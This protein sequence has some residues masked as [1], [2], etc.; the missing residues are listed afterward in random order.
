MQIPRWRPLP[1]ILKGFRTRKTARVEA[2]NARSEQSNWRRFFK[3]LALPI[4]GLVLAGAILGPVSYAKAVELGASVGR[5]SEMVHDVKLAPGDR[6]FVSVPA[7]AFVVGRDFRAGPGSQLYSLV[8]VSLEPGLLEEKGVS[9]GDILSV[10]V[11]DPLPTPVKF[12][13]S[14]EQGGL[15]LQFPTSSL[16]IWRN[17]GNTFEITKK[18]GSLFLLK[19]EPE[20]ALID[21]SALDAQIAHRDRDRIEETIRSFGRM[22]SEQ[23]SR[24]EDLLQQLENPELWV[25]E[26]EVLQ[27]QIQR[28]EA[29]L[30]SLDE[31]VQVQQARLEKLQDGS[32]PSS[33]PWIM[34]FREDLDCTSQ[35]QLSGDVNG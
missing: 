33:K 17:G 9:L 7:E 12:T 1:P 11:N 23:S 19:V 35:N 14:A 13:A 10:S 25:E 34:P 21:D 6:A 22:I 31:D 15:Q 16:A 5:N 32:G 26:K 24:V 30:K 3:P 4:V 18:D 27:H 28:L 2:A 8:T 20:G 29:N